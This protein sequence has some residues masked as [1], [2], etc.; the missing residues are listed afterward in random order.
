MLNGNWELLSDSA[1][2]KGQKLDISVSLSRSG[3]PRII[4]KI[5]RHRMKMRGDSLT[6]L[7]NSISLGF[8]TK[9]SPLP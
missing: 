5:H 7:S 3:I 2:L 9:E 6:I 1:S 4:P 8:L